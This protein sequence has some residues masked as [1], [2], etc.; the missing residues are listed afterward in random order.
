MESRS[1]GSWPEQLGRV[2][3]G[4]NCHGSPPLAPTLDPLDA[5]GPL[6]DD[7]TVRLDA[8]YDS[9]KTRT[10]S[11]RG[12]RVKGRLCMLTPVVALQVAPDR[13]RVRGRCAWR[14]LV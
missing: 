14:S 7:I 4:A 1:G 13:W 2:P 12:L 8:G 10:T 6:P 9:G 5:L 3:A 11:T